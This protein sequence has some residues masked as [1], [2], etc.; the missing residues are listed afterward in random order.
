MRPTNKL[1]A[2]F[3]K[4]AGREI[5]VIENKQDIVIGGKTYPVTDVKL[6]D[7]NDPV[8]SE[9]RQAAE[10]AGLKLR[11]WLP[12]SVGTMDYRTD[13]LNVRV[14]KETD[15]KYRISKHMNIG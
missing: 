6:K 5:E 7:K 4:F 13:R 2:A 14:E 9:L 15:G 12:G 10:K 8:I 11:L 3:N 1:G